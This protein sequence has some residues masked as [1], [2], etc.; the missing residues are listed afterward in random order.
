MKT[1]K[2]FIPQANPKAGYLAQKDK[3]DAAIKRVLESGWYILGEEVKSFED[4]FASYIG[5]RNAIGV[6]SGTDAIEIALAALG[7][8]NKDVVITVANTAIAT[9]SAIMNVGAEPVFV[10]IDPKSFCMNPDSLRNCIRSS[11]K[12]IS[13]IIPV[14][15][16]G[17]PADMEIIIE[18]A[19]EYGIKVI[20]D[21]A[22]AHGAAINIQKVGTFGDVGCFSFYPTKNLGAIG[23]GGMIVTD[24]GALATKMKMIRQYGWENRNNSEL[25]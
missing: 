14:H 15:L 2:T 23:D 20:E 7:I 5:T 24:D 10:D 3:I 25:L 18:I 8:S 16:Y 6:A 17:N 4:E 22:Q 12:K 13:A 19:E 9:V 11:N 1:N 21:C